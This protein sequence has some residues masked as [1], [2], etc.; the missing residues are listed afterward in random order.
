LGLYEEDLRKFAEEGATFRAEQ[1]VIHENNIEY[2][3]KVDAEIEKFEEEINV[4]STNPLNAIQIYE[5]Q[6]DVE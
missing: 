5:K 3:A 1:Q 2:L 4:K 6:Q